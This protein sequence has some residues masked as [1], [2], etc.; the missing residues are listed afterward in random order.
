M[1]IAYIS[2]SDFT[3]EEKRWVYWYIRSDA[4]KLPIEL[5]EEL[6]PNRKRHYRNHC[7]NCEDLLNRVENVKCTTRAAR[8]KQLRVKKKL[9]HKLA[10][11][12]K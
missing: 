4:I 8:M 12:L 9:E 10:Q 2:V 3:I 6:F 5:F 11:K 7:F 1:S